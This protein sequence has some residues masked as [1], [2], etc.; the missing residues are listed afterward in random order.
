[1]LKKRKLVR[2]R[3][4]DRLW[5]KIASSRNSFWFFRM[6]LGLQENSNFK[7]NELTKIS[8]RHY[9]FWRKF[10]NFKEKL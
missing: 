10:E 4:L 3:L 7:R 5:I 6:V 9:I 1:M 8:F 2:I